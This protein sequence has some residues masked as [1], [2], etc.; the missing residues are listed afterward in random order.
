MRMTLSG[1]ERKNQKF[2]Y[3]Q[4]FKIEKQEI[5]VI[6]KGKNNSIVIFKKLCK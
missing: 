6:K 5:L 3:Q 2:A 1:L 4:C